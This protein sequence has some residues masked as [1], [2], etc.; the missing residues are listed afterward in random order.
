MPPYLPN[1]AVGIND[2]RRMYS[3][4]LE[5]DAQVGKILD[6][7]KEDGLLDSTIVVWYSDHGGPLPRQKRL[8][9]DAGIKVPMIIRFPNKQFAGERDDRMI[10]FIDLAPT[11]LSVLGIKPKTHMDGKA[12]LG[13]YMRTEEPRYIFG[14]SD[15][16]DELTDR[17]RS[18]RDNRYKYIRYYMP[19]KPM[20]VNVEYR[21]QQPI[22]QELLRLHDEGKLTEA[23]ALWFRETKP[24]EEFF[25]TWNDPHEIH[26]LVNDPAYA[27]KIA[28]MRQ[29]CEDWVNDINDT[30]IIDEV[31]LLKKLW[32][33]G[34]Q[35]VTA[36]PVVSVMNGIAEITC[37]TEGAS[38]GYKIVTPSVI[39]E[40]LSWKVYTEKV[41]VP[42]NATLIAIAHRLGFKRS[43]P[44]TGK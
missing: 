24:A 41:H 12:F 17:N 38:I 4:I 23:Q 8:L 14:A 2:V 29:A 27:E 18:V 34:T 43:E 7:L 37:V 5:M 22:M 28:E 39:P 30:G 20:I 25:D 10:S 36:D 32:P 6:Q 35:P 21:K 26:N 19:E 3:N 40:S 9:F 16:F 1:T 44:V 15:R 42:P 33:K 31:E 13:E 11:M